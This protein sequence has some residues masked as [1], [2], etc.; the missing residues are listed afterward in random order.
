VNVTGTG[1]T[2]PTWGAGSAEGVERG[3][4]FLPL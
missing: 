3:L 1:A 2:G 4:S